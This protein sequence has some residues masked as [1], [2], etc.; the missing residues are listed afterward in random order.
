M[1]QKPTTPAMGTICRQS[2]PVNRISKRQCA[3]GTTT[4]AVLSAIII[5][6][7]GLAGLTRQLY[8]RNLVKDTLAS[9]SAIQDHSADIQAA[10]L[11]CRRYEKDYFLN[12]ADPPDRND[13]L[14]KWNSAWDSLSHHLELIESNWAHDTHLTVADFEKY[15]QDIENYKRVFLEI[16]TGVESGEITSAAEANRVIAPF[17]GYARRIIVESDDI[18]ER[19]EQV[20]DEEYA[21]L[22]DKLRQSIAATVFL[23]IAPAGLII[24]G[25]LIFNRQMTVVQAELR[26]QNNALVK[27]EAETRKLAMV[28]SHTDSAVVICDANQ[29]IEWV[30]QSF[31]RITEQPFDDVVNK[32]V[33]RAFAF[34][35][36]SQTKIKL[37]HEHLDSGKPMQI[38]VA[39][40]APSGR[41]YWLAA[42]VQPVRD[43]TGQVVNYIAVQRDVT[44]QKIAEQKLR[45]AARTDQLTSLSNRREIH[46]RIG[47]AIDRCKNESGRRFALLF[48]DFD[49]FKVIN[50]SLGHD[51]GDMLLVEIANRLRSY[52]T[53]NA[54]A[55]PWS[56]ARLGGDEF[57]LL[58]EGV[59]SE[60]EIMR[61]A[62][63]LLESLS[64]SYQLAGNEI[65]STASIGIVFGDEQY[66]H[67]EDI[68]RDADTAMYRAKASGK[69]R[70]VP[71]D[72][73]MLNA[74][75]A[76]Q[77]LETDLHLATERNELALEYQPIISLETGEV[78]GFEAL[79]RWDHP[80]LGRIMPEEFIYIAEES[81]LI[82]E[83]GQWVIQ[84][85][86][87]QIAA[88]HTEYPESD[89]TMGI[90]MSLNQLN[91]PGIVKK[92]SEMIQ[93]AGA[94]PQW[95][96]L[97]ISESSL[98]H[99]LAFT[100]ELLNELKAAGIKVALDDFG[101]GQSTLCQLQSLPIDMI[102]IDKSVV[103][104][105]ETN[106]VFPAVVQ[107]IVTLTQN[108]NISL[109]AEGVET[110]N[111]VAQL[112]AL[113][114]GL[115]QGYLLAPPMPP[116]Q[117][118][119]HVHQKC[120]ATLQHMLKRSA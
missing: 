39:G 88:W 112:Q 90:N 89:W 114:C 29:R 57:V 24:I 99:D 40:Q 69:A 51:V 98:M 60:Q 55:E 116:E 118:M 92:V 17:K 37:V 50:D 12:I 65:R 113:E 49:R 44:R 107:S 64:E 8:V 43:D 56:A 2:T 10:A 108:L 26:E 53:A 84:H 62:N 52:I 66:D 68:I 4:I 104:N 31:T 11:Q 21:T 70:V 109:M 33:D 22:D 42:D 1:Q 87:E 27:Q 35:E 100:T 78:K 91:K 41:N 58:M 72:R 105:M 59:W 115:A 102:K 86:C 95:I 76:R 77:R 83:L 110:A 117:C 82:H 75:Q 9:A 97:E 54:G 101:M 46:E 94:K 47:L 73:D 85:A 81:G 48:L 14:V 45:H 111:Q 74:V 19:A 36:D 34:T 38:E 15:K 30:N 63:T 7:A 71:F 80:R 79:V 106:L 32:K 93:S 96:R 28:A 5:I 67:A 13:Y 3:G 6:T 20:I 103:N 120:D 25:Q 23:M 16:T 18:S 61:H 119:K